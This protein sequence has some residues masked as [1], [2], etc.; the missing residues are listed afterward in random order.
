MV[1][2]RDLFVF[3]RRVV[4]F[5]V[6]S[7]RTKRCGFEKKKRKNE[8]TRISGDIFH[9]LLHTHCVKQ[10]DLPLLVG[11]G[12]KR[13]RWLESWCPKMSIKTNDERAVSLFFVLLIVVVAPA[14]SSDA[15][16]P[17]VIDRRPSIIRKSGSFFH[18]SKIQILNYPVHDRNT[19][20]Q[21]SAVM[22]TAR[23]LRTIHHKSFSQLFFCCCCR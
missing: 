21:N 10:L 6:T 9:K 20:H 1:S 3:H 2:F 5:A 23:P 19:H 11:E 12:S 4:V 13:L 18:L 8:R 22:T 16:P 15:W 7:P 17:H 14:F